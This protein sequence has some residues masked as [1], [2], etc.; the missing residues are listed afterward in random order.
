M[1]TWL[2]VL[3]LYSSGGGVAINNIEMGSKEAC[4]TVGNAWKKREKK[5]FGSANFL[6][7]ERKPAGDDNG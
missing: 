4:F 7:Y 3:T 5:P 2:L 1:N 6:C